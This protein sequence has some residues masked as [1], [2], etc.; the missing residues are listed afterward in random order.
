MARFGKIE[1]NEVVWAPQELQDNKTQAFLAGYTYVFD[2]A[3]P[4]DSDIYEYTYTWDA[5]GKYYRK[6]WHKGEDKR[7]PSVRRKE[8]YNIR[9]C[10]EWNGEILTVDEANQI[11]VDYTCEGRD[12][13]ALIEL[14]AE[15]KEIIRKE[16]PDSNSEE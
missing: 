14:I 9:K 13:T 16:F 3:I 6:H 5:E 1:N 2:A 12:M 10:V 4:F 8:Q 11:V 7:L 15:Q